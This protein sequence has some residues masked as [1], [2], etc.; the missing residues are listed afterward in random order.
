[1]T[2]MPAPFELQSVIHLVRPLGARAHDLDELRDGIAVAPDSSLF[3]HTIQAQL[4]HGGGVGA[5]LR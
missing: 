3:V 2:V 1:M 5:P 4:R